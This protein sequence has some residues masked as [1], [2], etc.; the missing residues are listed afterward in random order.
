LNWPCGLQN[1]ET[2]EFFISYGTKNR[3]IQMSIEA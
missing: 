1:V 3:L 2:K